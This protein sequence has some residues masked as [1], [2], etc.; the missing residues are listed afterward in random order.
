[1]PC[2]K[3]LEHKLNTNGSLAIRMG[4]KEWQEFYYYLYLM[5]LWKS[6]R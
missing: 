4:Y 6:L 5:N 1:M 3:F 2:L